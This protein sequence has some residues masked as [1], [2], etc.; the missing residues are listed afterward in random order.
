MGA[1]RAGYGAGMASDDQERGWDPPSLPGTVKPRRFLPK[2]HYELLACGLGGHELVGTD[3]REVRPEDAVLVVE[4]DGIRWYRCLRC[5]SWLPLPPPEHP[6]RD[7]LPSR[8]EL[9]LPLR[10]R[11]LRDKFVLRLIAVDRALHFV[12]LGLL[13]LAV[14]LLAANKASLS[15]SFYRVMSDI[16]RGSGAGPFQ[17]DKAGLSGELYK[18]F[19]LKSS[20]LHLAGAALLVYAALE[21]TEAVGLW[22][23]KRWAEYLTLVATALF[24]PLEI[25]ELIHKFTPFKIIAFVINVAVVIYLLYAKRLFGLR[26]GAAAEKAE[27]DRDMGWEALERTTPGFRNGGGVPVPHPSRAAGASPAASSAG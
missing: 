1:L 8:E 5:D 14:L 3:S 12:L 13:G 7:T 11:A 6:T 15:G 24:L 21:G 19:T 22:F 4:Q 2:F 16:G 10:G 23:A 25:W 20:T 9:E 17:N 18:L 27:R 26:G